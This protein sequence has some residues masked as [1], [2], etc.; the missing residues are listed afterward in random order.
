M[1]NLKQ[2]ATRDMER[3]APYFF[4]DKSVA[5]DKKGELKQTKQL[6]TIIQKNATSKATFG[7]VEVSVLKVTSEQF[8]DR[9][10][11]AY[12]KHTD[13]VTLHQF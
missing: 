2:I 13:K 7:G 1:S 3:K 8:G 9:A 6:K 4:P 11:L 5:V 10:Y 12:T